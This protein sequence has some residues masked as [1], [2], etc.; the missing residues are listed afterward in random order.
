MMVAEQD[1]GKWMLDQSPA[2]RRDNDDTSFPIKVTEGSMDVV[3]DA[4]DLVIR[5]LDESSSVGDLRKA[6]KELPGKY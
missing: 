2:S 4:N 6:V 3:D 1:E 5:G